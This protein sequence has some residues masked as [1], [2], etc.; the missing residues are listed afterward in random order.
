M[1]LGDVDHG[2]VSLALVSDAHVTASGYLWEISRRQSIPR[3]P[4]F[5]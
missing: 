2:H 4:R 3:A 5:A 1:F